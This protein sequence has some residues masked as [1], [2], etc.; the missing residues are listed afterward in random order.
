MEP[1]KSLVKKKSKKPLVISLV[2]VGVLLMAGAIYGLFFL[3]LAPKIVL[4]DAEFLVDVRSWEKDGAPTVIWTFN[5]LESGE[6][7]TNKTNYY[8][9]KWGLENEK[10]SFKTEWLYEISDEFEFLLNREE[11]YFTVKNLADGGES[12]FVPLGTQIEEEP[13]GTEAE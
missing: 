13:T 12:K 11:K 9:T 2:I 7:T 8:K 4:S 6:I 5:D 3:D 10:L 1:E